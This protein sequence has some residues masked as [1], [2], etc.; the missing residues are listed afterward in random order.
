MR[1]NMKL[2]VKEIKKLSMGKYEVS[3]KEMQKGNEILTGIIIG[4]GDVRPT[5]Y[6][7]HYI[8]MFTGNN[9]AEVARQIM[10][11]IHLATEENITKNKEIFEEWEYAKNHL[12]LCIAPKGSNKD[13]VVYP[14]LDLELY[15]RVSVIVNAKL[16][17]MYE[18]TE[19]LFNRWNITKETLFHATANKSKSMYR[20]ISLSKMIGLPFD[21]PFGMTVVTTKNNTYG[22]SVLYCKE[23]LKELADKFNDDLIILP[24][25]IHEVIVVPTANGDMQKMSEMVVAVNTNDVDPQEVL[26]DHAYIFHRDTMEITY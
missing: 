18:V 3:V 10:L 16:F 4:N 19:K 14:Y 15:V 5:V 23:K 2:L 22:A 8:N 12:L 21:D 1:R 20:S 11:N 26:S 9:Y 24:S 6:A 25:S 17:E 7:E 13:C